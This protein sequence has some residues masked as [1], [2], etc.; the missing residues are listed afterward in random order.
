[1]KIDLS[2]VQSFNIA[3]DNSGV[4]FDYLNLKDVKKHIN[5]L[6]TWKRARQNINK[7]GRGNLDVS[8]LENAITIAN[9]WKA[10][11]EVPMN[12]TELNAILDKEYGVDVPDHE[13]HGDGTPF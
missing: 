1:M 8:D 2:K 9:A 11:L 13:L 10:F 7:N 6:H 12:N 4:M 3:P 5:R